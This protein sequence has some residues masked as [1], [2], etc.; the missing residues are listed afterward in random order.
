MLDIAACVFH[1]IEAESFATDERN[2][3]CFHFAEVH[4]RCFGVHEFF[5]CGVAEN[6]MRDFMK[7]GLVRNCCDGTDGN[8]SSDGKSLNVAVHFI[9]FRARDVQRTERSV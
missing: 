8:F 5:S 4:Q 7:R 6:T 1:P 3:F 9:K 2:R